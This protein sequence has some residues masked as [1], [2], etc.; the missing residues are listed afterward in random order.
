MRLPT[1]PGDGIVSWV[2]SFGPDAELLE[3]E[4]LRAEI[5]RRL[6]AVLA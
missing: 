3:P 4:P 6:E 1:A 5:V 2:L